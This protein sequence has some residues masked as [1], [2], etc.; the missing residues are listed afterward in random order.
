MNRLRLSLQ[1]RKAVEEWIEDDTWTAQEKYK[2]DKEYLTC[3]QDILSDPVFKRMDNYYQHGHTTC[4]EHCIRVSYMSYKI[5]RKYGWDYFETARAALLHDLF[6]Y[7]W[8]THARDTG[9]HFHGFTHPR[10]AMN[11]ADRYFKVTEKEK[12]MILCHMWPLTPIPPRYREG[13]A[14]IYADKFCGLSEV[15]LR[16]K[17]WFVGNLHPAWAKRF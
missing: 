16:M 12:N 1:E 14:I 2:S 11:N 5:C 9:E 4:K 3:V 7:D 8:H 13:F 17:D 6:L 15:G 10:V